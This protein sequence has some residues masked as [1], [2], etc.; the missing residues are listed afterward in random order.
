MPGEF[1]VVKFDAI[2][3]YAGPASTFGVVG[4]VVRGQACEVTGRNQPSS[5]LTCGDGQQGWVDPRLVAVQG[6]LAGVVVINTSAPTAIPTA[7]VP[8]ATPTPS[9]VVFSGWRTEL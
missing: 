2:N 9:P 7:A 5:Q 1:A 6:A 3:L 4:Q 8:T